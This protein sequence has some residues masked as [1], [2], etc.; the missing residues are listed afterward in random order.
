MIN[1]SFVVQEGFDE[2]AHHEF[3]NTGEVMT[4]L[5]GKEIK[6]EIG[7]YEVLEPSTTEVLARFTNV[8][9]NPP[10]IT[11]NKFGKGRAI[12]VATPAQP[13]IMQPLYRQLYASLGIEPGQK[14]PDD[15]YARSGRGQGALRQ[16][17]G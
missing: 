15:V 4:R 3:Y 1:T 7:F 13:Q 5:S 6:G 9:G 2:A 16:Y 14:T 8:E 12:Y 11:V 10:S 17:R